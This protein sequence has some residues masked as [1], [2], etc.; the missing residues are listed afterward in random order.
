M[1]WQEL[2]KCKEGYNIDVVL[3]EGRLAFAH[4]EQ[5]VSCAT[6]TPRLWIT[7]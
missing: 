2:E 6:M 1:R 7:K 3:L 5:H 4:K